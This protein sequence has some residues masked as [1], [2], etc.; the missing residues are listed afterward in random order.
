MG[1][2]F[3]PHSQ[4]LHSN[5]AFVL[6][7]NRLLTNRV[8]HQ[9]NSATKAAIPCFTPPHARYGS[10]DTAVAHIQSGVMVLSET[11]RNMSSRI[12]MSQSQSL[13]GFLEDE[14]L[15]V[16][17]RLESDVFALYE[18]E[19]LV[20]YQEVESIVMQMLKLMPPDNFESFTSARKYLDLLLRE[21]GWFVIARNWQQ[22]KLASDVLSEGGHGSG[23]RS[24]SYNYK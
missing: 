11:S 13:P 5:S 15:S 14:M 24:W 8:S 20:M 23:H 2:F 7:S 16:L 22:W 21:I 6:P 18:T 19:Q 17:T 10:T 1:C 9:S 4:Y 12:S 3:E